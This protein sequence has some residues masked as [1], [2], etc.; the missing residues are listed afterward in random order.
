MFQNAIILVAF[1]VQ[2]PLV[3]NHARMG[4][5]FLLYKITGFSDV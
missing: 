5:E 3:L 2:W 4:A 1:F